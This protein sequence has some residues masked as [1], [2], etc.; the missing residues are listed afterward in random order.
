MNAAVILLLNIAMPQK[1]LEAELDQLITQG[2]LLYY[3]FMKEIGK[4]DETSAEEIKEHKIKLPSF[5]MEYDDWYSTC[6][7]VVKQLIP[8][9]LDDFMLQY[10]QEKRKEI[11]ALTYTI[12]DYLLQ[13]ST[14]R[15]PRVIADGKSALPKFL[16]QTNILKSAKNVLAHHIVDII[17]V[18]QAEL[19][20]SE[21]NAASTL[22]KNG[23]IRGAGAMAGVV[24]ERHLKHVC[25]VHGQKSRKQ[26][27]TIS[28]FNDLL[29]AANIVD[30]AK[31]RFIQH[32]GDIRNLCDHPKERDPTKDDVEEL[33]EGVNKVLKT[34]N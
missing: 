1:D 20:D 12:S 13:I 25:D 28:E 16:R 7:P 33:V 30:M 31:W 2:K 27:P 14:S 8:D 19:F 6:I 24:L 11:D 18:L 5:T 10:K 3:G 23:F 17:Q 21:L 22:N 15:G 32:L 34:V 4:L 29:K 9:R 26:H